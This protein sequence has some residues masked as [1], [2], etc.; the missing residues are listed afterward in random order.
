MMSIHHKKHERGKKTTHKRIRAARGWTNLLCDRGF[1]GKDLEEG[2][3]SVTNLPTYQRLVRESAMQP[4]TD[5]QETNVQ[6]P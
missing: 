5:P 4:R 1:E 3:G 6:G 2:K